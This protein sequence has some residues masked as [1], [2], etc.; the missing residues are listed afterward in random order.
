M[1]NQTPIVTLI[2]DRSISLVLSAILKDLNKEEIH[3]LSKALKISKEDEDKLI[4]L[5]I[6]GKKVDP[7]PFPVNQLSFSLPINHKF[8][9]TDEDI[10]LIMNG[11]ENFEKFPKNFFEFVAY[12][13]LNDYLNLMGRIKAKKGL[14]GYFFPNHL[15]NNLLK[16]DDGELVYN[17]RNI[18]YTLGLD[19]IKKLIH[20]PEQLRKLYEDILLVLYQEQI[21]SNQFMDYDLDELKNYLDILKD[22]KIFVIQISKDIKLDKITKVIYNKLDDEIYN[23]QRIIMRLID[24]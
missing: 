19:A 18:Q 4:Q 1:H 23:Q 14:D 11:I 16:S 7:N 2:K 8:N 15:W 9:I 12:A 21:F 5:S 6:M 3:N 22:Y 17:I 10:T 13:N 20:S 24:Q